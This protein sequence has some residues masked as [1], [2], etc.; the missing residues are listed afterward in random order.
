[1]RLNREIG[2]HIGAAAKLA[3]TG[4]LKPKGP[5]AP[6]AAPKAAAAKKP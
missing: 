4:K 1:V 3:A 2:A 6:P 5:K